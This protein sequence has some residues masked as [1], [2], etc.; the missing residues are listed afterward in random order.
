MIIW[1]YV[2]IGIFIAFP[3][4]LIVGLMVSKGGDRG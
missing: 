2:G 3:M 1:A 4:I